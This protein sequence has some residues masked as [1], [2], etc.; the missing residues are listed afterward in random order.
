[1]KM[2]GIHKFTWRMPSAVR[3]AAL[4]VALGIT[5]A[6]QAVTKP[7]AVWNA[8]FPTSGN[9]QRGTTCTLYLN[10]NTSDGEKVTIS[11]DSSAH[12]LGVALSQTT[13]TIMAVAGISGVQS[14]TTTNPRIFASVD[15]ANQ[16]DCR[17]NMGLPSESLNLYGYTSA[18][19]GDSYSSTIAWPS[20]GGK[21]YFGFQY[22]ALYG[23]TYYGTMG[24]VNGSLSAGTYYQ[25]QGLVYNGDYAEAIYIG[26]IYKT[27]YNLSG[28][29]VS[30]LAVLDSSDCTDVKYWSELAMTSA[31]TVSS[32]ATSFTGGSGVG[33]NLNGG[34]ITVTQGQT[35]QAMFVQDDT[36]L[37][38]PLAAN[39]LAI[40]KPLYVADGK[41]L[42]VKLSGTI[43]AS[44]TTTVVA[45]GNIFGDVVVDASAIDD[46]NYVVTTTVG[47]SAISV[48]CRRKVIWNGGENG[49]WGTASNWLLGDNTVPSAAPSDTTKNGGDH[50]IFNTPAT[51]SI[52]NRKATVSRITLN[53]DVTF[54]GRSLAQDNGLFFDEMDGDGKLTLNGVWV[55]T[56][57]EGNGRTVTI[58]ND[59]CIASD[60]YFNGASLVNHIY[61]N[62]TGSG[63]LAYHL[64]GGEAA[65]LWLHG[66]NSG[67]SGTLSVVRDGGAYSRI[68]LDG[69]QASS[70]NAVWSFE[71]YAASGSDSQNTTYVVKNT[72][73]YYFGGITGGFHVNGYDAHIEIGARE[74]YASTFNYATRAN[75]QYGYITKVGSN[76]LTLNGTPY[77]VTLKGGTTTLGASFNYGSYNSRSTTLVFEGSGASLIVSPKTENDVTTYPDVSGYIKNSSAPVAF[78]TAGNDF[79]WATAL[80]NSNTGGLTKKGAG[81]LTLTAIPRYSG[82]TRV[83]E[84]TLV[85]PLGTQLGDVYVAEGATLMFDLA[86][87]TMTGAL[88]TFTS[89]TG[90]GEVTLI[91]APEGASI[92]KAGS[93]F[94][95]VSGA[96]TLTW[97]GPTDDDYSW[98]TASNW[99]VGGEAATS[100][101][102]AVD[103]VVFETAAP[104]VVLTAAAEA[105]S[106]TAPNGLT[107]ATAYA[108]T[109]YDDFTVTGAF[110]KSG[111]GTLTVEGIFG[112]TGGTTIKNG[113][114][115]AN[116]ESAQTVA[117]DA[118]SAYTY[119]EDMTEQAYWVNSKNKFQ[120]TP[121]TIGNGYGAKFVTP[122]AN[123]LTVTGNGV[124]DADG[125][126]AVTSGTFS[127]EL[128]GT[129]DLTKTGDGTFTLFGNH[130]FDGN[131]TVSGGT[132]KLGTPLDLDGLRADYDASDAN[133][134]VYD[135]DGVTIVKWNPTAALSGFTVSLEKGYEATHYTD[136]VAPT[137][138]TED[139]YAVVQSDK[140]LM[141]ENYGSLNTS[142]AS[143][144]ARSFFFVAK[145]SGEGNF[146]GNWEFGMSTKPCRWRLAARNSH[147]MRVGDGY[148]VN[149]LWY[150]GVLAAQNN[151]YGGV[152]YPS[153]RAVVSAISAS[154]ILRDDSHDNRMFLGGQAVESWSEALTYTRALSFDEKAAVEQYL[155]AKWGINNATY[156][157]LP[158]TADVSVAAGATLDLGGQTVTVASLNLS[159]TI[160]NGTI[161]VTG[162]NLTIAATAKVLATIKVSGYN[163]SMTAPAGFEFADNSDGTATLVDTR[164][165]TWD[166]E[167]GNWSDASNWDLGVVPT[168]KNAVV[169][170]AG[171]YTVFLTEWSPCA[172]MEVKGTVTFAQTGWDIADH[173]DAIGLYGNSTGNGSINLHHVGLNNASGAPVTFAPSITVWAPTAN[174]DSDSWLAGSQINVTG[175]VTGDGVIQLYNAAHTFSGAVTVNRAMYVRNNC[176]FSG[177]LTVAAGKIFRTFDQ[178]TRPVISGALTLGQG[179]MFD[180][181]ADYGFTFNN[182]TLTVQGT[183]A[184][185]WLGNSAA[186][187]GAASAI[188]GSGFTVDG[189]LSVNAMQADATSVTAPVTLAT[190]AT[191]L[192]L[193]NG[194]SV[195]SID[196]SVSGYEVSLDGNV[197]RV[198]VGTTVAPNATSIEYATEEEATTAA[199]G[200]TV[201]L[202]RAQTEQ[203][204]EA[205]YYKIETYE[206][207]GTWYVRAVLDDSVVGVDL[208]EEATAT[209]SGSA[210]TITVENLKPGLCYRIVSG[211][212]ADGMTTVGAWSDYYNGSN[213]PTLSAALPASGVMFYSVEASD[214]K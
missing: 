53:A 116:L 186:Y 143:Y 147:M 100:A 192:T 52:G 198:V 10:G 20:D 59:V 78:D 50:V 23:T 164:A 77:Y 178:L 132:L 15:V 68:D 118:D 55:A 19:S 170:P 96:R 211:S 176:T 30:F 88:A 48:T 124:V 142:S 38:V 146:A 177:G 43:S 163:S 63:N 129:M 51:V 111:K 135:E 140:F 109:V 36:T 193:V 97:A 214:T 152:P 85:V 196:T 3:C 62:L 182:V 204:L 114:I 189:Y 45:A 180:S 123:F 66:D 25:K 148:D 87:T 46:T 173:H 169:F 67:Y 157:A 131:V 112:A 121:T 195:T 73:T 188:D 210:V 200:Y 104:G 47:T 57:S 103:D 113:A 42:T 154:G 86:N 69:A 56:I 22:D 9:S 79:T 201:A 133:A 150:N 199:A 168:Y 60:S 11:G 92:K 74:D 209:V 127:G 1:M 27:G 84:G 207:D 205:G 76:T 136:I 194:G 7:L 5:T 39:A 99:T 21:H 13:R 82:A 156:A 90:D 34:T 24:F 144:F 175:S 206:S 202:T 125:A 16:S 139:G 17:I 93:T 49:D 153:S 110:V 145:T 70:A 183:G 137:R 54:V 44:G 212:S 31:E 107:L 91:N 160:Q 120:G 94:M 102:T 41:T 80:A 126:Y 12:G 184:T 181:Y 35:A 108:L 37:E 2:R 6:A 208:G 58:R 115:E 64:K 191:T 106:V 197:Y 122:N 61:G 179:A 166:G 89:K 141:N 185:I 65:H 105:F 138:T 95:V 28:A 18:I 187:E 162:N 101:P 29:E 72:D 151:A 32:S 155:M 172:G 167:D 40:A 117:F 158:A 149:G 213:A 130:T 98:S 83:E 14:A 71:C 75:R 33:V 81:T 4:A 161:V 159:G 174:N 190:A 26:G 128:T 119:D 203:G 134:F 8:D 165:Y 171:E